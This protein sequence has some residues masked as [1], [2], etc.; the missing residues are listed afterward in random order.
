MRYSRARIRH[1]A[2]EMLNKCIENDAFDV[3]SRDSLVINN[4]MDTMENYFAIEDEVYEAVIENLQ[5]RNKKLIPGSPEWE[6]AFNKTY[7]QE[8]SKRL[9]R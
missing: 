8:M 2:K 7:E 1:L 5:N 6:I 3:I 4:I 9:I